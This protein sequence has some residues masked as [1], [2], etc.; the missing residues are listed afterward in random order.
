MVHAR[1]KHWD[2]WMVGLMALLWGYKLECGACPRVVF[3]KGSEG[4]LARWNGG[5]VLVLSRFAL[6]F[7]V[8]GIPFVG[9]RGYICV[10]KFCVS[11]GSAVCL[12]G[13]WR[14]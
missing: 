7:V 14:S 1:R 8:R 10:C 13:G 12:I 5:G 3:V 9:E 11:C 2:A 6:V 4:G